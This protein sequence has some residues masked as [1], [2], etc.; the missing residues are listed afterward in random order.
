M[1]YALMKDRDDRYQTARELLTDFKRLKQRLSFAS[2]I[3]RSIAPEFPKDR[4]GTH[5][6]ETN[7]DAA[8]GSGR[9]SAVALAAKSARAR[10]TL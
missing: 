9:S 7:A 10:R 8:A 1:T 4:A 5:D 6:T 3:E 2:E